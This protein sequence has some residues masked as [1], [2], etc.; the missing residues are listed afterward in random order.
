MNQ[1]FG[2]G[3]PQSAIL[4]ARRVRLSY[5]KALAA[6]HAVRFAQQDGIQN[7]PLLLRQFF[8]LLSLHADDTA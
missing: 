6:G 8:Q 4:S 7:L 3:K 1:T 5:S 2:G